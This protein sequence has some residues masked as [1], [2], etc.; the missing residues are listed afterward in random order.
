MQS[1]YVNISL[2]INIHITDFLCHVSGVI[3]RRIPASSYPKY[4]LLD[5][6]YSSSCFRAKSAAASAGCDRR[7]HIFVS[8]FKYVPTK[9]AAVMVIAAVSL[10]LLGIGEITE[11]AVEKFHVLGIVMGIDSKKRQQQ[12]GNHWQD[13][14]INVDSTFLSL[15]F[16]FRVNDTK[17]SEVCRYWYQTVWLFGKCSTQRCYMIMYT[18]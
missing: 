17:V 10:R 1:R 9:I 16:L 13:C 3:A 12:R 7:V 15:F 5:S 8:R 2:P 18:V 6:R 14:Y 11:H 4:P